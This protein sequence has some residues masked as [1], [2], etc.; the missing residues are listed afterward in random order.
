MP[1]KYFEGE[2]ELGFWFYL[3][4]MQAQITRK[5]NHWQGQPNTESSAPEPTEQWKKTI[6]LN[7]YQLPDLGNGQCPL[8]FY[9]K[10]FQQRL[11]QKPVSSR[12]K[13]K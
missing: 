8:K 4:D 9:P 13:T 6:L 5:D 3:K 11:T 12:D 10:P 7:L 1:K 2:N